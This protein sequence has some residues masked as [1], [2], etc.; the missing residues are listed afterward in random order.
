MESLFDPEILASVFGQI[1]L[2]VFFF[3]G[4]NV[5]MFNQDWFCNVEQLRTFSNYYENV[6]YTVSA[7]KPNEKCYQ[8]PPPIDVGDFGYTCTEN[9]TVFVSDVCLE[10]SCF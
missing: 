10:T 5:Y 2:T 8:L 6:T 9:L 3:I 7:D 4:A 1:F